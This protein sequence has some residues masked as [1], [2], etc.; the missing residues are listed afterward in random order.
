MVPILSTFG[1]ATLALTAVITCC[2]LVVPARAAAYLAHSLVGD[3]SWGR[4]GTHKHCQNWTSEYECFTREENVKCQHND[5][6]YVHC[7]CEERNAVCK[8]HGYTVGYE[9]DTGICATM[10]YCASDACT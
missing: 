9:G 2:S 6:L 4:C 3:I 7:G 1:Y 10:R 8:M 5:K